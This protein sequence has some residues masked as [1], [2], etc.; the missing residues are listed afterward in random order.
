MATGRSLTEIADTYM[1][2]S[3]FLKLDEM[4]TSIETA[5][6]WLH[7]NLHHEYLIFLEEKVYQIAKKLLLNPENLKLLDEKDSVRFSKM[8]NEAGIRSRYRLSRKLRIILRILSDEDAHGVVNAFKRVDILEDTF[9]IFLNNRNAG[10]NWQIVEY[11]SILQQYR[12]KEL[13]QIL[14]ELKATSNWEIRF[15][16]KLDTGIEKLTSAIVGLRSMKDDGSHNE[17]KQKVKNMIRDIIDLHARNAR[18]AEGDH[19]KARRNRLQQPSRRAR[20]TPR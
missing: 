7:P 11:F 15:F 14:K 3:E 5:G 6:E 2:L 17:K 12:I 1:R 4:R 19:A 9:S 8:L 16:S 13:R 10:D 18:K 20:C